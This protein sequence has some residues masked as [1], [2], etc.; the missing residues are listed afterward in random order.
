MQMHF[1][2]TMYTMMRAFG[3]AL[4]EFNRDP[5][6]FNDRALLTR[7]QQAIRKSRLQLMHFST[8]FTNNLP[9][10]LEKSLPERSL[11]N[12]LES[13]VTIL[14]NVNDPDERRKMIRNFI[15]DA[16]VRLQEKFPKP[17]KSN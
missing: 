3:P 7:A 8:D 4:D 6:T 11:S 5:E 12:E 9:D 14:K 15:E 16:Q 13:A 17:T 1:T 10:F 2:A